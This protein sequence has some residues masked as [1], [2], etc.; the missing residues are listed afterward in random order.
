M[1]KCAWLIVLIGMSLMVQAG[2]DNPSADTSTLDGL[3]AD[4]FVRSDVADT[5]NGI[6]TYTPASW[7]FQN[8]VKVEAPSIGIGAGSTNS[9]YI[10]ANGN[11]GIGTI[12]PAQELDVD[13]TTR[14]TGLEL[15]GEAGTI[16]TG[17]TS[18]FDAG[19]LTGRFFTLSF[20]IPD[21]TNNYIYPLSHPYDGDGNWTIDK[22]RVINYTGSITGLGHVV[23]GDWTSISIASTSV[24]TD[25]PFDS[26]GTTDTSLSGFT[27][28]SNNQDIGVY[29]T[30]IPTFAN[31]NGV[32]VDVR[33]V[34]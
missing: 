30:G 27:T 29:F 26:S 9:L 10:A 22:I 4:Q 25:I 15:S 14:T 21:P 3:T 20:T 8:A 6:I 16:Y 17:T 2:V 31:T 5:I 28:I 18:L 12:T 24:E 34:K 33:I 19:S 7:I 32:K 11:V 13:G 1:N 23:V